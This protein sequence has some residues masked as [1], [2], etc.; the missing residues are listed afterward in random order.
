[1][2]QAEVSQANSE[3]AQVQD[4][5]QNAQED[6]SLDS[7]LSQY[8]ETPKEEPAPVPQPEAPITAEFQSFMDR[9]I[10]KDNDLA[11]KEAAA[12]LRETVGD[13]NLTD[14]WFKGQLYLAG[15]DDDRITQA[16]NDRDSNPG[17]WKQI[18]QQLGKELMKDL[19]P[20]DQPSTDSWNAVEASVHSS[21]TSK[22][23]E[24]EPDWSNMTDAEFQAAKMKLGR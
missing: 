12:L 10:K 13:T 5:E 17:R 20:T 19:A 8:H 9:Q 3:P 21:Q 1:M 16:F 14:K 22:S 18:V 11:L 24:T 23:T 2:T 15:A 6:V 4:A 7:L